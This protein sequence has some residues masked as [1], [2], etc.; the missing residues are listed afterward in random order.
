M[1]T[2][3]LGIVHSDQA[4]DYFYPELLARFSK[5]GYK[6]ATAVIGKADL[7]SHGVARLDMVMEKND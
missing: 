2:N 1:E 4:G 6:E 7:D 5:T 3:I